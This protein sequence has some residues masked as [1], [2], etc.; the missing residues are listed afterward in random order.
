MWFRTLEAN[1]NRGWFH[2]NRAT[3]DEKVRGPLEALLE[4]LHDEFGDAKVARPNRDIRFSPDKS[5]YKSQ[6]YATVNRSAGGGGWY[7]QLR[8]EGL[9]VGGGLYMPDRE[10]L[11]RVRAAIADNRTGRRLESIVA[12]LAE[13]GLDLMED[14]ALKTAPRGYPK[15]HPRIRLLR[16]PHLAAGTMYPPR[17]WLHTAR[18][19]DR[20]AD[21]W[22]SATPLLDWTASALANG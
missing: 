14:G 10:T 12:R 2:A 9:F 6:I 22:R 13:D 5:P 20:V 15:D 7:V 4:E 17:K 3:Y 11:T 8:E 18:A 21:G 19:I 16:L 1:N